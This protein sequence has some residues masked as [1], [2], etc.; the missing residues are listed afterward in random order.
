[1]AKLPNSM[2]NKQPPL[3][4]R[5]VTVSPPIL[6]SGLTIKGSDDLLIVNF[7]DGVNNQEE[8]ALISSYALPNDVAKTLLDS[9]QTH[10]D[11]LSISEE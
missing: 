10:F 6:V 5:N 9:I 8:N 11:S 7:L 1:M 4:R 3:Y 2:K